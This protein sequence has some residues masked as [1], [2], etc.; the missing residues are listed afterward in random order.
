M[1]LRV[2]SISKHRPFILT[3]ILFFQGYKSCLQCDTENDNI[4]ILNVDAQ[5][6]V[7]TPFTFDSVY[8]TDSLQQSVYDETAFPLVESMLEGYNCTIF[9]YGQT[10]CGK[11]HTMM[12][13]PTTK[14]ERGII[15]NCFAHIFGVIDE[16][17]RD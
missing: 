5:D 13:D 7:P 3:K 11:T 15:P 1:N 12:G 16:N 14:A 8:D 17:G 6:S 10:G 2:V 9:A 4:A